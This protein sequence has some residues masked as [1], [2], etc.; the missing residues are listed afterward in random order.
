MSGLTGVDNNANIM[1]M[2]SSLS[3]PSEVH[4]S[5]TVP[6]NTLHPTEPFSALGQPSCARRNWSS[7]HNPLPRRIRLPFFTCLCCRLVLR[8][9]QI[10]THKCFVDVSRPMP[11]QPG[12]LLI[13]VALP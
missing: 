10:S 9:G 1:D 6:L 2:R 4:A 11:H 8:S 5:P 3:N 13:C 7:S 12:R